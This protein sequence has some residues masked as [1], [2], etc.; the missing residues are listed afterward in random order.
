MK[1]EFTINK[2]HIANDFTKSFFTY[3]TANGPEDKPDDVTYTIK[4][5]HLRN[6]LIHLGTAVQE[7]EKSNF[8]QYTMFYENLLR[9]QHQLMYKK[10]REILTLRNLVETKIDEVNIEVQCQMADTCYDLIMGEPSIQYF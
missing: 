6:C 8:E 3:A 2:P 4:G 5:V 7:R 1:E 9:Q 10:E